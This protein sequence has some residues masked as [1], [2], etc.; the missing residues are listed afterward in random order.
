MN[1]GRNVSYTEWVVCVCVC[2]CVCVYVCVCVCVCKSIR[3]T[4]MNEVRDICTAAL[5]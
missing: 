1:T 2:V 4:R 5:L 3:G